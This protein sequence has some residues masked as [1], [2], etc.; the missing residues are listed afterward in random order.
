MYL[1]YYAVIN[2]KILN[3]FS[4]SVGNVFIKQ[5]TNTNQKLVVFGNFF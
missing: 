4:Y 1:P 5:N 3:T 2:L